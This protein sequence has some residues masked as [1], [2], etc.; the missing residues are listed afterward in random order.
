ML[1]FVFPA[2][3]TMFGELLLQNSF[4][5]WPKSRLIRFFRNIHR[6]LKYVCKNLNYVNLC[7]LPTLV[8]KKLTRAEFQSKWVT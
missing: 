5:K 4:R 7:I 3:L 2:H 6:I 8:V 1:C